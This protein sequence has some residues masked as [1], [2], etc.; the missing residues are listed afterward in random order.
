[1]NRGQFPKPRCRPRPTGNGLAR[2]SGRNPSAGT[3]NHIMYPTRN[4]AESRAEVSMGVREQ[5]APQRTHAPPATSRRDL[6]DEPS[7]PLTSHSDTSKQ[8]REG[9]V[10]NRGDAYAESPRRPGSAAYAAYAAAPGIGRIRK[11]APPHGRPDRDDSYVA[12]GGVRADLVACE[13][14]QQSEE[15]GKAGAGRRALQL[16]LAAEAMRA[17]CLRQS[18]AEKAGAVDSC[19]HRR[20]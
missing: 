14:P 13:R 11:R 6:T 1:M 18:D 17:G 9:C 19:S 12:M 20:D 2:L 7:T 4:H 5:P 8:G 15:D 10:Q 16:R 3:P